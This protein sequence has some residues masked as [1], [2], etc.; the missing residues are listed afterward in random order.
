M[1][2]PS[3]GCL[4]VQPGSTVQSFE[5]PS[6]LPALPSSQASSIT[7]AS[8]HSEVQPSAVHFGSFWQYWEQPS[9]DRPLPSSQPSEPSI[10][11]SPQGVAVQ[12][13]LSSQRQP[14]SSLH[15]A[16]QPSPLTVLPSSHPSE[17]DLTLSPHLGVQALP[18]TRHWKPVSTALQS[19][20]H[21]SPPWLLPSSHFSLPS[22]TPLPH[23]ICGHWQSCPGVHTQPTPLVL[24]SAEQPSPSVWLPSSQTSPME[25]CMTLSPQ[26]GAALQAW[27][28]LGHT[29]PPSSLQVL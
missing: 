26:R 18:T 27:P 19:A 23:F 28:G 1:L 11:L 7:M 2:S 3:S 21:P 20:A 12:L 17:L 25:A 29:Q 6:P 22:S 14:S 4:Q 15:V 5:Q 13:P 9:K 16:E 24:Q 8:P 10:L